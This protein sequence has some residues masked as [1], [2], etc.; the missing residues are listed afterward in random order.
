MGDF[1]FLGYN[2]PVAANTGLCTKLTDN[3]LQTTNV[4]AAAGDVV[5][6]KIDD[7]TGVVGVAT[8]TPDVF[9]FDDEIY[10]SVPASFT[11]SLAY[12]FDATTDLLHDDVVSYRVSS[13]VQVGTYS[14]SYR[15]YASSVDYSL[16]VDTK[17]RAFFGDVKNLVL[18]TWV[19]FKDDCLEYAYLVGFSGDTFVTLNNKFKSDLEFNIATR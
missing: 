7:T 5:Y 18:S 3:T 14:E 17:R 9:N 2:T 1:N 10:G 19:V 13:S 6:F 11:P 16:V 8:E 4:V 12:L 15:P